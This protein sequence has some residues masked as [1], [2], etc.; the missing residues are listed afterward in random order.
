MTFTIKMR[1]DSTA[2]IVAEYECPIHGIFSVTVPRPAPDTY[3]CQEI[4]EISHSCENP[5]CGDCGYNQRECDEISQYRFP[6]P[7]AMRTKRGEVSTGKVMD[8]PPE[9]VCMDTRPLAD[10]MPYDQWKAGR[11]KVHRDE[12]LRRV[13][14]AFGR[15][16]KVWI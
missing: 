16:R 6:T 5:P 7:G 13:R 4:V 14:N 3:R 2:P 12:S 15:T 11:A 8:Y 9:A 10:G 1:G